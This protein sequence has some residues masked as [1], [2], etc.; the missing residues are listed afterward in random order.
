MQQTP[1]GEYGQGWEEAAWL[2]P[3]GDMCESFECFT[4]MRS[5]SECVV[6]RGMLGLFIPVWQQATSDITSDTKKIWN[7]I[8]KDLLISKVKMATFSKF[9]EF[10]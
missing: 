4:L 7:Q 1:K 6:Y 8:R 10:G 5:S 2:A 9:W 3:P